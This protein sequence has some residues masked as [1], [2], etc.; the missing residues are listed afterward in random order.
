MALNEFSNSLRGFGFEPSPEPGIEYSWIE[1]QKGLNF[2]GRETKVFGCELWFSARIH[3]AFLIKVDHGSEIMWKVDGCSFILLC[4]VSG[5]LIVSCENRCFHISGASRSFIEH[6]IKIEKLERKCLANETQ[7]VGIPIKVS[8][9]GHI[10]TLPDEASRLKINNEARAILTGSGVNEELN[11]IL[12][13]DDSKMFLRECEE[14][15]ELN[16]AD[17]SGVNSTRIGRLY[18][19]LETVGGSRY[20]LGFDEADSGFGE[21]VHRRLRHILEERV[22]KD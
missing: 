13:F 11:G 1:I 16:F 15:W 22:Q 18:V 8:R 3:G 4:L 21:A 12:V 2:I 9:S 17:V 5:I 6:L 14:K 7:S 20:E 10:F 19:L